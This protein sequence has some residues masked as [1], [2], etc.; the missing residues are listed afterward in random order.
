MK[1]L[2][3]AQA[4]V[5][6]EHRRIFL[7]NCFQHAFWPSVWKRCVFKKVAFTK[8]S[9]L[10]SVFKKLCFDSCKQIFRFHVNK[11]KRTNKVSFSF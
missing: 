10:E 3:S 6:A 4:H 9:T 8:N 7:L 5:F 11:L 2:K 1:T